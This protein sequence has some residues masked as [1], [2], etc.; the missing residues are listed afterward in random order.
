M[1]LI[2]KPDLTN[3][4]KEPIVQETAKQIAADWLD[5]K[6]SAVADKLDDYRGLRSAFLTA[7]VIAELNGKL[8]L[9]GE[10][11]TEWLGEV[12]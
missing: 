8:N 2:R 10:T 9:S 1:L 7:L 11:F 4:Q 6:E 12:V 5:G 3:T